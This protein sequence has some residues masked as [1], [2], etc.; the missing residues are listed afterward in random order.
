MFRRATNHPVEKLCI[1]AQREHGD[2]ELHTIVS[3]SAAR[4]S[5]WALTCNTIPTVVRQLSTQELLRHDRAVLHQ[6]GAGPCLGRVIEAPRRIERRKGRRAI[7]LRGLELVSN[8]EEI[9]RELAHK[10]IALRRGEECARVGLEHA[11]SCRE[12]VVRAAARASAYLGEH[13]QIDRRQE[14][15][16]LVDLGAVVGLIEPDDVVP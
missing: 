10:E 7:A 16:M 12:R 13:H 3:P 6:D 5:L 8:P 4:P 9:R 14:R 2:P 1:N 11:Q 15:R